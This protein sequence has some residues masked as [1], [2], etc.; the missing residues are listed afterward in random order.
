MQQ[1]VSREERLHVK[2]FSNRASPSLSDYVN[3]RLLQCLDQGYRYNA[4][5]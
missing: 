5:G 1:N 4:E 3:H 2:N